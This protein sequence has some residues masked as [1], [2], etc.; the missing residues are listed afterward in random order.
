VPTTLHFTGLA[1]ELRQ[2]DTE[3]F[4]PEAVTP[5]PTRAARAPR[6]AAVSSFGMSGTNL[7]AVLE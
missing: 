6:R 5:W 3:L 1:E 7:H 4:V 2:I